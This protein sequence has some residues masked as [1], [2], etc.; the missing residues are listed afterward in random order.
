MN[1][2][3]KAKFKYYFDLLNTTNEHECVK[4][5]KMQKSYKTFKANLNPKKHLH[6]NHI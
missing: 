6:N 5:T 2:K 4:I 3:C 1:Y